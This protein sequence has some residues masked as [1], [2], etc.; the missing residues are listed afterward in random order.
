MN[1]KNRILIDESL[2]EE[3]KR[4][5][6]DVIDTGAFGI[7]TG[8]S[9]LVFFQGILPEINRTVREAEPIDKQIEICLD[10]LKLCWKPYRIPRGHHE[11]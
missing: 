8:G 9:D 6:D 10:R 3:S 2:S 1:R 7:Q 11:G 4:Q 5:R